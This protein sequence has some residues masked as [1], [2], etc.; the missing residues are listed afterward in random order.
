MLACLADILRLEEE[1]VLPT[2]PSLKE[3]LTLLEFDNSA[4]DLQLALSKIT[5]ISKE[6]KLTEP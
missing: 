5:V 2:E 1:R 3:L 4:E 6:P